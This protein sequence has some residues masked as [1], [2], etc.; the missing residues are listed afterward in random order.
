MGDKV[1]DVLATISA[2]RTGMAFGKPTP[3]QIDKYVELLENAVT[4]LTA[5]LKSATASYR[6]LKDINGQYNCHETCGDISD[7]V[8]RCKSLPVA[9]E[10]PLLEFYVVHRDDLP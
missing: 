6:A 5:D 10:P 7:E 4:E 9:P 8:G 3:E 2:F 1:T